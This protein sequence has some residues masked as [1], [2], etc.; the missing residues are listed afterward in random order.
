M[1]FFQLQLRDPGS[2]SSLRISMLREVP[3]ILD[4]APN[5]KYKFP[6]SL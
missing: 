5:T 3:T 4:Q 1:I 2:P 6:K